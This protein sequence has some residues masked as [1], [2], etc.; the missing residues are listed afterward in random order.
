MIELIIVLVIV[1]LVTVLVTP[2]VTKTLSQMELRGTSKKVSAILRFCR[3]ESVNRNKVYLA[4]FNT[5]TNLLAVL[6]AGE[7]D[8]SPSMEHSYPIPQGLKV[9]KVEVGQAL[10]EMD[11]PSFEFYPN[12]GSNGGTAV[13]QRGR[14]LGFSIYVDALTGTVKVQEERRR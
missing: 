8:E 3:S 1:S 14:D 7:E 11:F 12:G 2:T 4:S 6:S 10:F 13:I 5:S 9:E